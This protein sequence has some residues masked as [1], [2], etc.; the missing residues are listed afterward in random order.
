MTALAALFL[1]APTR[2]RWIGPVGCLAWLL[3]LSLFPWL[4]FYTGGV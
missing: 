3:I 2:E 1:A 4:L